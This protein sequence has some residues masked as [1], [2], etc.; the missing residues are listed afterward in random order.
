MH[1]VLIP[2]WYPRDASDFNGSFFA[3]QAVGLRQEGNKVGVLA[4]AGEPLYMPRRWARQRRS[5]SISVEDGI[6]VYRSG[7]IVPLPWLHSWNQAFWDREWRRLLR[8]YIEDHGRPDVL[9]A[10]AMFPAGIAAQSLADEFGI[11]Y[12]ITEHRPSSIDRLK[13]P[14]MRRLAVRA[15]RSAGALVAVAR[16]FVPSLDEAYGLQA[17]GG[18]AYVPGMLSPQ[19]EEIAPRPL[20]SEPFTVGHVSHLD[21]GKRVGNLITAFAEAFPEGDERLRIVGDSPHRED[22]VRLAR[23]SGVAHR[24]DFVGAVPRPEIATEFARFHVFA[25]PSVAEAFGTVLWEAMASGVPLISTATWA[26]GNAVSSE[27]GIVVPIDDVAALKRGL[28]EIRS[29]VG[30]YSP[31]QIRSM[32]LSHCGRHAFVTEYVEIY[33]KALSQ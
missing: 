7:I 12:V 17:G 14:G 1:V 23:E 3:E 24:I 4:V 30:D 32:A 6:P 8:R 31:T 13:E 9:H 10:H 21:P 25:L 18:W 29:R 16:G 20:P 11:P 22:L 33:R 5:L 2:S 27:N 26:G 28:Q 19:F 15:A